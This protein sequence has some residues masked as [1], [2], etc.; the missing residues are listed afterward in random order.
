M[1]VVEDILEAL[2]VPQDRPLDILGWSWGGGIAISLVLRHP[3][4]VGRIVLWQ[5]SYTEHQGELR[6]IKQP[7]LVIWVPVDQVH[8]VSLGRHFKEVLPRCDYV[9][10]NVGKFVPE[11]GRHCYEA[12]SDKVLPQIIG[13]L[14]RPLK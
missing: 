9:E 11:K 8:P 14:R 1:Q 7:T 6:T 2:G 10:V 3:K 13:W 5:G 12:C 4:R